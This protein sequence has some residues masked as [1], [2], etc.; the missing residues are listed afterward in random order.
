VRAAARIT[1]ITT[2]PTAESDQAVFH[3]CWVR[4]KRPSFEAG[5]RLLPAVLIS[6]TPDIHPVNTF[7]EGKFLTLWHQ[8][9]PL[10]MSRPTEKSPIPCKFPIHWDP[11]RRH[12]GMQS[13]SLFSWI[14]RKARN[15]SCLMQATIGDLPDQQ[16]CVD[17]LFTLLSDTRQKIRL[18][19]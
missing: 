16:L 13:V 11:S 5:G 17:T 1:D 15:S 8:E 6:G 9:D 10:T 12:V 14:S 7:D 2:G 18:R 3:S 4:S 19:D